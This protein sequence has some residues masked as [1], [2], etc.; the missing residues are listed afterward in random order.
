M[1]R[2]HPEVLKDLKFE[3]RINLDVCRHA[4]ATRKLSPGVLIKPFVYSLVLHLLSI[5]FR[6]NTIGAGGAETKRTQLLPTRNPP[7]ANF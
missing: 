7:K 1:Q 5:Y 3:L 2:T 6:S 4:K